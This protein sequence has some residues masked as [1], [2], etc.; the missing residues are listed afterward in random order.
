[1]RWW[2]SPYFEKLLLTRTRPSLSA[3]PTRVSSLM[4]IYAIVPFK[5]NRSFFE[6]PRKEEM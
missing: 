2:W 5:A 3:L 4:E 6:K 1:M